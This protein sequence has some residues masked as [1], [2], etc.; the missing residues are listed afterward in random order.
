MHSLE[1]GPSRGRPGFGARHALHRPVDRFDV[2]TTHSEILDAHNVAFAA[3]LKRCLESSTIPPTSI[4][5]AAACARRIAA[6]LRPHPM[7]ERAN[8]SAERCESSS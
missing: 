2:A 4:R 6:A 1:R 3:A 7:R 8:A 5:I